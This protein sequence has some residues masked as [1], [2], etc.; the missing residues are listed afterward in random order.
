MVKNIMIIF[1]IVAAFFCIVL[2]VLIIIGILNMDYEKMIQR[3]EE[4][5]QK[6]PMKLSDLIRRCEQHIIEIEVFDSKGK[7]VQLMSYESGLRKG[8][9]LTSY[10]IIRRE[11][12][13]VFVIHMEE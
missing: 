11:T 2:L 4:I 9:Y 3:R 1:C 12:G 7:L 8:I 10:S 13:L 5:A 6:D